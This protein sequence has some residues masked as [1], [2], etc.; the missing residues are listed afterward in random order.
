MQKIPELSTN[1][2]ATLSFDPVMFVVQNLNMLAQFKGTD[3]E[4]LLV[5][6]MKRETDVPL[7]EELELA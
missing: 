1:S 3:P 7:L 4:T 5:E 2:Q 6:T